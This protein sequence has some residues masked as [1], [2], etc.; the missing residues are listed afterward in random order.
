MILAPRLMIGGA[1]LNFVRRV[2]NSNSA[3]LTRKP[4][5]LISKMTAQLR[6]RKKIAQV[7]DADDLI[8]FGYVSHALDSG[9]NFKKVIV[10]V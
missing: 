1:S 9:K 6:D 7:F 2:S 8:E 5:T 3:F 4:E 10:G